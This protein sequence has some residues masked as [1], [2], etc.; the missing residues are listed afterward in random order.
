MKLFNLFKKKD[1]CVCEYVIEFPFKAHEEND[2]SKVVSGIETFK[3][4]T[5]N[6]KDKICNNFEY[7]NL[8]DY[9]DDVGNKIINMK[10]NFIESGIIH[11][12]VFAKEDLSAIN[13]EKL[14]TF[15]KGQLSDG[16]GE[17]GFS[18]RKNGINYELIFWD[19]NNW[20]IKYVDDEINNK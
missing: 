20:Y 8:Q 18:F 13:K 11:I 17:E 7:S 19:N 4:L 14:L 15:I 6:K 5:T 3:Y 9:F 16:W 10:M 12:K 1:I 2:V